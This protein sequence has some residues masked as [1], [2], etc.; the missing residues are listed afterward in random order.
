MGKMK[1]EYFLFYY[2]SSNEEWENPI[3]HALSDSFSIVPRIII[4]LILFVF[5]IINIC[6][7]FK[8]LLAATI[9][10]ARCIV[11]IGCPVVTIEVFTICLGSF[12]HVPHICLIIT[13]MVYNYCMG[14]N[15]N[16]IT[17]FQRHFV[18]Y[19]FPVTLPFILIC[20]LAR[21]Y[22]KKFK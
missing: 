19:L 13:W 3:D 4:F 15:E 17:G 5:F 16:L 11:E 2:L 6:I 10:T 14:C 8:I 7:F 20:E 9:G 1:G 18:C 12:S 21:Y 22:I